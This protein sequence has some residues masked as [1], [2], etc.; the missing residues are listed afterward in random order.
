MIKKVLLICVL[1]A[2]SPYADV[3]YADAISF[4]ESAC[5]GKVA[6]LSCGDDSF[7]GVCKR[8]TCGRNDYSDGWPPTTKEVSCLVCAEG[9]GIDGGYLMLFAGLATVGIATLYLRYIRP[10]RKG[11]TKQAVDS[12]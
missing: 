3:V 1:F 11:K 5:R 4:E 8:D 10:R 2:W 6:G 7:R 12:M 9:S